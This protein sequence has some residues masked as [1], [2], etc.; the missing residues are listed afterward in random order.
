[1]QIT[2]NT[3]H[4]FISYGVAF[5]A[6]GLIGKWYLWP[7]I[8]DRARKPALTPLLLYA[9]LRVNGLMFVIPGLVSPELP[10]TFAVPTAY[11]D[12]AAVLLALI[13]LASVRLEKPFAVPVLW[14]FNIV[15]LLDLLWGNISSLSYNVDPAQ[16]GP[17]YYLVVLNV[18]AMIV[19]HIV[20]IAYLLRHRARQ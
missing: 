1:M 7:S 18:P 2:A 12:L 6:F 16:W 9:C 11:G 8:K 5:L 17:A 4:F 14:L 15:G 20:M 10:S 3:I 19:I 13:A